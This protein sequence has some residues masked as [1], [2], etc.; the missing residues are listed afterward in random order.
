M[1][2]PKD[3]IR[4]A[5]YIERL[6]VSHTGKKD[7]E[8]TKL[9]KSESHKGDKHYAY[10]KDLDNEKTC[11]TCGIV[12]TRE[13]KYQNNRKFCSSK[14]YGGW[15][16]QQPLNEQQL[17]Q[18]KQMSNI[19]TGRECKQETRDKIANSVKSNLKQQEHLNKIHTNKLGTHVSEIQKQKQSNSMIGKQATYETR[20]K[21]SIIRLG[22]TETEWLDFAKNDKYCG[23]WTDPKYKIRKRAR[24]RTGDICI[25]CGKPYECNNN[26]HMSVHHVYRKKDACCEGNETDWLFATL[27]KECHGKH[28]HNVKGTQKILDIIEREYGNKTLLSLDEY[29]LLY[30][31]GSEGDNLIY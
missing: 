25:I 6:R 3:P 13:Q 30:P 12:L 14:C 28:G 20:K 9:K 27:C 26:Q 21:L 22:I 18:L 23:K 31:N 19:N 8:E 2:V 10:R 24:A 7:T 16:K 4:Y 15:L 5:E 1:P 29:N 17:E 11:Q